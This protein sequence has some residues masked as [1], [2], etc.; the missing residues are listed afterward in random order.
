MYFFT[1]YPINSTLHLIMREL[2]VGRLMLIDDPVK[3]WDALYNS[4]VTLADEIV[5][6]KEY[7]VKAE[8]P[9]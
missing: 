6:K 7:K 3:C 1:F 8:R 4:L 2:D 9:E 5:P